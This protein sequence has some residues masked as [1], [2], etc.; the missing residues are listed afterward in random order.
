MR[1]DPGCTSAQFG[2]GGNAHNHPPDQVKVAEE[3]FVQEAKRRLKD[4]APR[5]VSE[6]RVVEYVEEEV[7]KMLDQEMKGRLDKNALFKRIHWW[8]KASSQVKVRTA[9][10]GPK[11]MAYDGRW[12]GDAGDN[13]VD[14]LESQK[15]ETMIALNGYIYHMN[16]RRPARPHSDDGGELKIWRC[17]HR[18]PPKC[19]GRARSD[20]ALLHAEP[21]VAHN[22]PPNA[23]KVEVAKVR[24]EINRRMRQCAETGE[25]AAEAVRQ[26]MAEVPE[27]LV[28]MLPKVEAIVRT[29][30]RNKAKAKLPPPNKW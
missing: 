8:T 11:N 9:R 18:G 20:A 10:T 27:E 7:D 4:S 13:V 1:T 6:G 5:G 2:R 14:L 3:R 15:G 21:Y 23:A 26:M 29:G 25:N 30:Q 28:P 24:A 22:H 16:R 12:L 19:R 17:M